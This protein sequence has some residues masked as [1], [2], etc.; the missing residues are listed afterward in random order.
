VLA[1]VPKSS[2]EGRRRCADARHDLRH[3]GV[4]GDGAFGDFQIERA[5]GDAAAFRMS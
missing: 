1:P 2:I 3:A 5:F 4:G